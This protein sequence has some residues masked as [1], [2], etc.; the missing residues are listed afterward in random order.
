M[1]GLREA[2]EA[3]EFVVTTELEPPKGTDVTK[4][5]EKVRL[6]REKVHAANVTDNQTSVM[7]LGPLAGSLILLR[8]GLDPVMQ[9]VCRDKNRLAIQSEL[10]SAS[11]LGI[12]NIL[13]LTGDPIQIG[14]HPDAKPVFDLDS[15]QII[16]AIAKLN[17]GRDFHDNPLKGG[18]DL[19]AGA[20]VMPEADPFEPELAKFE[21]KV[22]AGARF[23]QTQAV[24]NLERFEAFMKIAAR[25]PVKILCGIIPLKSAKMAQYMNAKVPGIKVPEPLIRGIEHA[26]DP[27]RF[28]IEVAGRQIRE[29]RGLA[30]GVHIMTIGAEERVPVILAAAEAG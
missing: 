11:V 8:E 4:L 20:A 9:V 23:F 21:R 30:H 29:V 27:V 26:P 13:T 14:D 18:T 28:G 22:E 15:V 10:L 16:Q 7:R 25:Y 6:L 2:L 17:Q 12:R 19:Y 3:G 5:V 24:Y 1:R